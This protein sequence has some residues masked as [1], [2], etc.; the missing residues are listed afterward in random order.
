MNIEPITPSDARTSV[1]TSRDS[2]VDG[3]PLDSLERLLADCADQPIWR[4]RSDLAAAYVDGKQ[5]TPLQQQALIAEGMPE[6]KPTNLIGRVIRS[7][8]GNEAKSRTDVKVESD[9]DDISDVA[10]V[11]NQSLSEAKREARADTAVSNAYAGQVGPGIGWVEVARAQ[12]PLDYPYRVADVHR[13]EMWWDWRDQDNLLRKARWQVRKRWQDLDE[14]EASMPQFR[15]LL[16]GMA[17]GWTG[18]MFDNTV[19]E[20]VVSQWRSDGE[21]WRNYQRRTE[22]FDSARKRVKLYEVWYKVPAMAVVMHLGPTRRVLFDETNQTHIQ[23]VASRQV[24]VSK[25]LTRQVRMALFAGPHRLQDIGTTRRNFPYIPFF[26]YRDDEDLTPYGLVEGMI[27]PQDEYN[28]RRLRINWLLRARQIMVDNDAL[29]KEA[30]T[31]P[32]VAA[33]IMRPDLTVVLNAQRKNANGFVVSQNLALEKEQIEVMQDAKQLIQDV[34]GVYGSQLGQAP[35]GV[36][37]GI[38]NSLLI[39]QG[40]VAMGDLNDGYRDARRSVFEGLLELI[41][42][43]HQTANMQIKIGRGSARRVVVLNSFDE[44]G[45]L[46]NHVKDAPVRVG[47]GEAPST[48]AFRMQQQQVVGQII[49]AL[50]Q[51]GSAAGVAVVAPMFIEATDLPNRQEA[52][53]DLRR[54]T[55][56]PTAGD[57]NAKQAAEAQQKAEQA[58]EQAAKDQAMQ[59]AMQEQVAKV[60]KLGSEADRNESEVGLNQAK[61]VEIG[62]SMGVQS[63][64]TAQ[65]AQAANDTTV[66]P[67]AER[68]MQIDAAMAE[69]MQAA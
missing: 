27:S 11:L 15:Q 66:D 54:A 60:R 68:Q 69:A 25:S 55:G 8:L 51:A 28:S 9:D 49:T 30:N 18:F 24:Q 62:H 34:P 42:E 58:K 13:S 19:D 45:N 53:D 31:L 2:S 64:Q 20:S 5:L 7:I 29:D 32:E 14:L 44:Q 63:L 3:Y 4:E 6:V 38:A 35:A 59:L 40:T 37:S 23:A 36:T 43:D 65:T 21:R 47:L 16:R 39:E 46:I 26:A 56:V 41:V 67:E 10:E 50:A 1:D 48:P 57:K 17:N 61:A 33:R 52:A 22:W 12:D